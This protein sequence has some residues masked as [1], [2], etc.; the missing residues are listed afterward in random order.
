MQKY[1]RTFHLPYSQCLSKDDKFMTESQYSSLSSL[2]D[3]V[4]TEKKDGENRSMFSSMTYAR[5]MNSDI[6]MNDFF[7]QARS[8]VL[9]LYGKIKHEIPENIGIHGEDLYVKH[10]IHYTHLEDYFQVFMMSEGER[11][12]SW[13]DTVEYCQMLGLTPVPVLYR[14]IYNASIIRELYHEYNEEGDEIEGFVVRNAQSFLLEEFQS[15]VGKFVRKN[16]V[17]TDE[18]WTQQPLVIN[19]LKK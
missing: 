10:S 9:S 15:H 18:H 13:D 4:V 17:Q 8:Y 7:R 14:G 1:P 3:V 11:M 5:S 6:N 12:L 19:Q 2:S 16:H